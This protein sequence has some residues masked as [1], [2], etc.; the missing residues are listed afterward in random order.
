[1]RIYRFPQ[2]FI[3]AAFTLIA[4]LTLLIGLIPSQI[5]PPYTWWLTLVIGSLSGLLFGSI[6]WFQEHQQYDLRSRPFITKERIQ[7]NRSETAKGMMW[8]VITW[9][10]LNL[11]GKAVFSTDLGHIFIVGCGLSCTIIGG[12]LLLLHWRDRHYEI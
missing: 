3:G 9:I 12:G 2:L 10:V 5:P 1:M 6:Y 7:K 8:Y 4:F 11:F